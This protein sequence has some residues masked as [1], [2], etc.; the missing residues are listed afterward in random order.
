M[1]RNTIFLFWQIYYLPCAWVKCHFSRGNMWLKWH[2]SAECPKKVWFKPYV[3]TFLFWTVERRCRFIRITSII[4]VTGIIRKIYDCFGWKKTVYYLHRYWKVY[5]CNI[6][7]MQMRKAWINTKKILRV[8]V[9][10]VSI[11]HNWK[12]MKIILIFH[13]QILIFFNFNVILE[14]RTYF[15]VFFFTLLY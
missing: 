7:F 5:E 3:R 4:S 6:N 13:Y 2:F 14:M 10:T 11:F 1:K 12:N 9:I 15:L 8:E